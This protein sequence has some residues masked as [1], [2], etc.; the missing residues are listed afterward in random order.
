MTDKNV[1]ADFLSDIDRGKRPFSLYIMK[2][3]M[4]Y[5]T[6]NTI[7]DNVDAMVTVKYIMSKASMSSDKYSIESGALCLHRKYI[8]TT[9][10]PFTIQKQQTTMLHLRADI[11]RA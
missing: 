7:A 2:K 10:N 9:T 11:R 4:E 1:I 6:I 3:T 8:E 5:N